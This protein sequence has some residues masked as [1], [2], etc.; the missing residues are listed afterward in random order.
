MK[1]H[2]QRKSLGLFSRASVIKKMSLIKL[3]FYIIDALDK[4]TN[5]FFLDET[6]QPSLVF[7]VEAKYLTEWSTGLSLKQYTKLKSHTKRQS[8]GHFFQSISDEENQSYK[9]FFFC[10]NDALDK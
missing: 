2:T 9:N 7:A 10:I 6:L 8:L 3:F 1:S 4:W 5:M